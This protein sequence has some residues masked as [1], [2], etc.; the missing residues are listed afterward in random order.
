MERFRPLT[1]L[2]LTLGLSFVFA[3]TV[4]GSG[5]SPFVREGRRLYTDLCANCHGQIDDSSKEGRSMSR[6]RSALRSFDQ[7][8][9]FSSLPD[10]TIL[11][12]SMALA[13]NED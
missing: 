9:A 13:E 11:L 10:E 2:F 3:T 6:I 1:T 4:L 12:I 7:H 5:D 8:S